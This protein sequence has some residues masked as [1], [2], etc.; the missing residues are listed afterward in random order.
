MKQMEKHM[1]LDE[2]NSKLAEKGIPADRYYLHGRYGSTDDNDKIALIIKAGRY[3]VQY[4]TYFRERG[5][6]HSVKVFATESEACEYVYN[7]LMDE[8]I[9]LRIQQIEGL[10][11]MTVNERLWASGL[12]DEFDQVLKADKAS[13]RKI[14]RWL[15]VDEASIEKIVK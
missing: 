7:K 6:K 8:Q 10:L 4:E 11:G 15:K 12:M 1:T 9:F 13:A 14:L 3:T 2:L 5:E